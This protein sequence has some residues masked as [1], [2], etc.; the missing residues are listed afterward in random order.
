MHVAVVVHTSQ[1]ALR[2]ARHVHQEALLRPTIRA[3]SSKDSPW[4][5]EELEK[6]EQLDGRDQA[7]ALGVGRHV[8]EH[9][10]EAVVQAAES[11]GPRHQQLVDRENQE[12]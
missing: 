5:G 7:Q 8:A 2:K 6:I 1:K 3:P 4:A 12:V 11:L 9:R 10:E